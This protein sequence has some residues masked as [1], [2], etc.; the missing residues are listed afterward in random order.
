MNVSFVKEF[1]E[2]VLSD[3]GRKLKFTEEIIKMFE[4]YRQ[5]GKEPEAGGILIGREDKNNGNLIIEYAT[6]PMEKDIRKRYR[7]Y[8]K[9]EGHI[10]YYNKIY[11]ENNG[12]YAY[13]GEWHTHPENEPSP[14]LIDKN[15]WKKILN[16]K[17]E[18]E[19]F[20]V[21]VGIKKI[22]IWKFYNRNQINLAG[23]KEVKVNE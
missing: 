10:E 21:I 17:G 13:V 3:S 2:I 19:L 22:R 1:N 6:A 15:N 7:F 18:G 20:N 12:I 4:S 14:S 9:D 11:K 8:R 16:K 5:V 23:E